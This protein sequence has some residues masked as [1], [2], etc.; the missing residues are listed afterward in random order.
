MGCGALRCEFLKNIAM[1]G[2]GCKGAIHI[3][4]DDVIEL[5]NLSRQFLFRRKHVSKLKSES[6]AGVACA[7]NPEIKSGI[8]VHNIRV[9]PKTENVFNTPFWNKLDFV[10]N[11][12]DNVHARNYMDGKC[13]VFAKPLLSR[14]PSEPS[15]C[16]CPY[17]AQDAKL[18]GG[19]SAWRG[20]RYRHVH[21][22]QF[23]LRTSAL[24]WWSRT[25]FG[26]MFED[27]PAAY[28]DLRSAGVDAFLEKV[29]SNESEGLDKPECPPV[30]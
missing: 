16:I 6:A 23:P 19:I 17:S 13:V 5:S 1:L 9:E 30:G 21:T 7:M 8:N 18:Q 14:G 4:D 26:Q 25:M 22:D 3:T 28:E 2:L 29:A 27:G 10:I 24:Y 20:R 11:A 12:L 15:Q